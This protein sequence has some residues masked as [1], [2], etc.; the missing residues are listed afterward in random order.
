MNKT[1]LV[2]TIAEKA[3]LTKTAAESAL[4]GAL[5]AITA[6]LE[7]G[8]SVTLAGFGTFRVLQ[9]KAREGRN[10]ATGKKIRIAAK[11][12]VKFKPGAKLA[13]SVK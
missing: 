2:R 5:G 8:D 4:T 9:R 13:G 11:K 3:E 10:P 6:A 7:A 1:D 12:V